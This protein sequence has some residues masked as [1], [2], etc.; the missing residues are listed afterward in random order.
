MRIFLLLRYPFDEKLGAMRK[1]ARQF[2]AQLSI[3][4]KWTYNL[5]LVHWIKKNKIVLNSFTKSLLLFK[6]RT[7]LSGIR[8]FTKNVRIIIVFPRT[9]FNK[10]VLFHEICNFKTFQLQSFFWTNKNIFWFFFEERKYLVQKCKKSQLYYSFKHTA[11]LKKMVI[12]FFFS[13]LK[14][15]LYITDLVKA[16]RIIYKIT[17]RVNCVMGHPHSVINLRKDQL[18]RTRSLARFTVHINFTSS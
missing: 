7:K 13:H 8:L 12:M 5:Y 4:Y 1:I 15:Y 11:C 9:I 2:C 16:Y 17:S 10:D 3:M 14:F 18:Y 6:V